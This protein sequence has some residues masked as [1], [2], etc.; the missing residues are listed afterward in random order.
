M[1]RD[2]GGLVHGCSFSGPPTVA[3]DPHGDSWYKLVIVASPIPGVRHRVLRHAHLLLS[4]S[5]GDK[6]TTK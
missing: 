3:L 1:K 4:H 6:K 5:G 2:C